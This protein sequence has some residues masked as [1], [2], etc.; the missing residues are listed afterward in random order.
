MSFEISELMVQITEAV[1]Q[2]GSTTRAPDEVPVCIPPSTTRA[3]QETPICEP[4][5]T[6]RAPQKPKPQPKPDVECATSTTRAH[7]RDT[8]NADSD[9]DAV[10]AQMRE[11]L[12]GV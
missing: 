11:Q 9:L 2:P 3:P 10:L 6:T 1:C 8:V 5:S 4:G 7:Y 12:T